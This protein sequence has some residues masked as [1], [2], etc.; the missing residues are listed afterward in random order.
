MSAYTTAYQRTTPREVVGSRSLASMLPSLLM[1]GLLTLF[2]TAILRLLWVGMTS[3][4][5]AS[6]MEAWLTTWPIAFPLAY[7]ALPV[8]QKISRSLSKPVV[9]QHRTQGIGIAAVQQV[10]DEVT[11]QNGLTLRPPRVPK[12]TH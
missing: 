2:V 6:W 12:I 9:L 5:F 3:D 10:S 7:M 1:T 11:A 4:F 8:V